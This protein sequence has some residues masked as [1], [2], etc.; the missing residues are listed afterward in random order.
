M[1]RIS[2]VRLFAY[3]SIRPLV[4]GTMAMFDVIAPSFAFKVDAFGRPWPSAHS[5]RNPSVGAGTTV[6][7]KTYAWAVP[8]G[9]QALFF[10]G[11]LTSPW[12]GWPLPTW[13]VSRTRQ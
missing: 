2:C 1:S 5:V 9:A 8:G 12:N 6:A 10:T 4:V 11:T 3:A 13:R 7:F